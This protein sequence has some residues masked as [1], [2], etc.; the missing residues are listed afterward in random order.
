M[1]NLSS[2]HTKLGYDTEELRAVR[3]NIKS[4]VKVME[5]SFIVE[6]GKRKALTTYNSLLEDLIAHNE[7][8]I[9]AEN[10][11]DMIP[12]DFF[13]LMRVLVFNDTFVSEV[14]K[15]RIN[16]GIPKGG[17]DYFDSKNIHI[18][19]KKVEAEVQRIL[20]EYNV[21]KYLRLN[22]AHLTS[23]IKFNVVATP[24]TW[25]QRITMQAFKDKKDNPSGIAILIHQPVTQKELIRFIKENKG[26]LKQGMQDIHYGNLARINERGI[27]LL[28]LE[29]IDK[30]LP[31]ISW[32]HGRWQRI[33]KEKNEAI[34]TL[35]IE[36]E[37][38]R[39]QRLKKQVIPSLFKKN[40]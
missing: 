1:R 9:K 38:I 13:N 19:D 24:I 35:T 28:Y 20:S 8:C 18:D 3:S 15:A 34:D 25:I 16:S 31:G 26:K 5:V 6:N 39:W 7:T 23:I 11:N 4:R 21:P 32:N 17:Y 22:T 27:E 12:W 40:K 10:P 36:T 33:L 14:K 29:S 30:R 2:K 37:R